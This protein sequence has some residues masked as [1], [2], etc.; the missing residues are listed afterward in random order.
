MICAVFGGSFDPPHIGHEQIVEK[1]LRTLHVDMIFVVPTYL[2]PFKDSFS[3]PATLRLKW[4]R[5]LFEDNKKVRVLDY[6]VKQ[7]R[8][9]ATIE[10]VNYLLKNY[11]IDKIYLI[12]GADN[13]K[14]LPLWKGYDELKSK[15]EFVVATRDDIMLPKELKKIKI[16]VN[17][18]SLELR[19]KINPSFIPGCI[20]NEVE[21]FY[22]KQN[23]KEKNGKKS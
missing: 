20:R 18:S 11:D 23:N 6:E 4:L 16:N 13:F 2:N 5:K 10:T 12:I 7:K 21:N 14:K 3:A 22:K 17:I 9:V 15:V 19:D 1:A 8:S